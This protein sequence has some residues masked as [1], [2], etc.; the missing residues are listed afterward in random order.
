MGPAVAAALAGPILRH[1]FW[2][3]GATGAVTGLADFGGNGNGHPI[4]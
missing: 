1:S 4:T 2:S 3:C